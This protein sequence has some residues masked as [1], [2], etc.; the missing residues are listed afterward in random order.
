MSRHP[1]DPRRDSEAQRQALLRRARTLLFADPHMAAE[2]RTKALALLR[3]RGV[4]ARR[5]RA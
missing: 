4:L 1:A 2:C 3:T 5:R